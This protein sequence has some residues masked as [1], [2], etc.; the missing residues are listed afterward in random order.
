V[1]GGVAIEPGRPGGRRG[2]VLSAGDLEVGVAPEIGGRIVSLRHRG[3]EL[4]FVQEEF[5]GQTLDLP[6]GDLSGMKREM[7]RRLWGGDKTW[8]SPQSDWTFGIPPLRLDGGRYAER[9]GG[10]AVE[11]E[12]PVCDETGLVVGR[13]VALDA[14]GTIRLDQT[15]TN[16]G[17]RTARRG[18]WNVTQFLRPWDVFLPVQI[19]AL[20]PYPEEGDSEAAKTLVAE[21]AGP[22]TR[23]RCD[24][25]LH[26]K[27]GG[28]ARH[29]AVVAMRAA[30]GDTL[31]HARTFR[32]DSAAA[33]AHGASVEVYNAPR[34]DYL[35]IEVHAPLVPLEPGQ[36][37]SHA[38][39][40]RFVRLPGRPDPPAI[41]SALGIGT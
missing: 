29:G 38:Q 18:I 3:E 22:W 10:N 27:F 5:A 1:T 26:F 31:V 7:G 21:A 39:T 4:L 23:V 32:V 37:V 36:S 28:M 11:M 25:A 17:D 30:G 13:R 19:E 24:R 40:W 12:S 9:V 2:W 20:R 14:D 41:L 16:R 6:P 33:Y 15:L 35:E 34:Y 8:V